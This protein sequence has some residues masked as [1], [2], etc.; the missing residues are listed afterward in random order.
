MTSDLEARLRSAVH[1]QAAAAAT[2]ADGDS[3]TTIRTRVRSARRRRRALAAVGAVGLVAFVVGGLPRLAGL[4]DDNQQVRMA[5]PASS[6]MTTPQPSMTVPSGTSGSSTT[7]TTSTTEVDAPPA[8]ETPTYPPDTVGEGYQP[9]WPF[10]TEDAAR[11][12]QDAY[13][14]GGHQPWHLDADQTALSFTTGFLGFTEID[15]VISHEIGAT[16]AH[17]A[18]GYATGEGQTSTAAVIHLMRFGTGE[19]APWEVV[20][21]ADESLVLETPDY[22]TTARS[23][24]IVGGYITGVD[25]SLRV[26]VRQASSAET[27]GEACCLPAGGEHTRWDT[28]VEFSGATD[29]ALT[30]VVSTG[31]HV[32]GVERFAITGVRS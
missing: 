12:W 3:L 30:I 21:T 8:D 10:P 27:L 25:E 22:A 23:P 15:R 13:R 31:G 11:A 29:P 1:A 18:L 17:V 4:G 2:Q 19:D 9:L 20:G 14:T 28:T 26:Q 6:D 32:Q 16:D 7:S 24:L 5:P